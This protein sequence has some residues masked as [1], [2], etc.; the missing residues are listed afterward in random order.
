MEDMGNSKEE[1]EK[2]KDKT[3]SDEEDKEKKGG[4]ESSSDGE[5]QNDCPQYKT[6]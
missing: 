1:S 4:Q 2:G 3:A 5:E 6:V